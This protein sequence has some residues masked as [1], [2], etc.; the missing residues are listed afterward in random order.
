MVTGVSQAEERVRLLDAGSYDSHLKPF[1]FAELAARIRAGLR[2]R[3]RPCRAVL[4]VADLEI[5]RVAPMVQ[6]PRH[7]MGL[8][9]TEFALLEFLLRHE[10]QAVTQTAIVEQVW[11][12]N[13]DTMTSVVDLSINYLRRK[14]DSG[15]ARL[16]SR[17]IRGVG[18]PIGDNGAH[19]EEPRGRL[20]LIHSQAE[21]N[22]WRE[23]PRP[24]ERAV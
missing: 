4:R 8:S 10:G 19:S 6:R 14:V 23:L 12:I 20:Y 22:N 7:S 21:S 17:T 15:F 9:P 16:L 5:D 13:F 11:I 1:A 24:T 2:R 18:Y 3:N